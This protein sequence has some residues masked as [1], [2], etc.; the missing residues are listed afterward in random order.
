[1]CPALH[2]VAT[3][4]PCVTERLPYVD[5]VPDPNRFQLPV[6][7]DRAELKLPDLAIVLREAGE[8]D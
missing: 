5:T 7:T 3:R 4:A 8:A 2:G 1:V 6:P